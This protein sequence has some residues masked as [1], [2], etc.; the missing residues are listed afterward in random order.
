MTHI[1]LIELKTLI[2]VV[3]NDHSP[4]PLHSAQL[5]DSATKQSQS[6]G[7][8]TGQPRDKAVIL[9]CTNLI[10]VSCLEHGE[11][12]ASGFEI[13]TVSTVSVPCPFIRTRE[14]KKKTTARVARK[15]AHFLN[16]SIYTRVM[17]YNLQNAQKHDLFTS[18][19]ENYVRNNNVI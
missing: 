8:M 18:E 1:D 17:S 10:T 4:P 19:D 15:V 12:Y 6:L 11:F 7:Q 14:F 5:V 13:T 9:R 16:T 3:S 2:V